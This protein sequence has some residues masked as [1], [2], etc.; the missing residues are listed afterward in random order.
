MYGL[1]PD[2]MNCDHLFN[3]F[4]LYGNEPTLRLVIF[5]DV[6]GALE[7]FKRCGCPVTYIRAHWSSPPSN[8]SWI[9]TNENATAYVNLF[10]SMKV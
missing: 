2:R 9:T 4:Y 3:L 1:I 5:V 10:L 7:T 6:S 8:R